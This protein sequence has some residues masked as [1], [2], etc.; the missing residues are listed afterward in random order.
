MANRDDVGIWYEI[1]KEKEEGMKKTRKGRRWWRKGTRASY[2]V[3]A[4]LLS[5]SRCGW[6]FFDLLRPSGRRLNKW[7]RRWRLRAA[8]SINLR[9]P[10]RQALPFFLIIIFYCSFSYFFPSFC[11]VSLLLIS[12]HFLLYMHPVSITFCCDVSALLSFFVLSSFMILFRY[13]LLFV[14][15]M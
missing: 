10:V 1:K 12:T 6:F 13:L 11:G 5:D 2:V 3:V 4:D 9:R 7:A 14:Y 8:A 15:I